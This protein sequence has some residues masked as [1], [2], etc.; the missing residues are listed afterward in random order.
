MMTDVLD[1]EIHD[2]TVLGE[3]VLTAD[4]MIAANTS[5]CHLSQHAIDLALGLATRGGS[6]R[7]TPCELPRASRGSTVQPTLES[8]PVTS[9]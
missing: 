4:L 1:L 7:V 9:R 6:P 3:L 2:P 8:P 5:E